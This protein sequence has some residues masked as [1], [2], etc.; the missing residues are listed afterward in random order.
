MIFF[1]FKYF[2]R[3][4]N[5]LLYKVFF[6]VIMLVVIK[7]ENFKKKAFS[8]IV[9]LKVVINLLFVMGPKIKY[10]NHLDKKGNK[11]IVSVFVTG[12]Y[13]V[14]AREIGEEISDKV[15]KALIGTGIEIQVRVNITDI[16]VE[17][18]HR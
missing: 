6:F 2:I 10:Y 5:Y 7:M 13:G 4:I 8:W 9:V 11:C 15:K 3:F 17:N 1:V 18:E 14:T 12:R 16:E